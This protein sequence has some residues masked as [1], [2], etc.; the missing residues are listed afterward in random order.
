MTYGSGSVSRKEERFYRSGALVPAAVI[1]LG[2]CVKE[3][4]VKPYMYGH[5]LRYTY[6]GLI[7][8]PS[9]SGA[10]SQS[11]TR[12]TYMRSV[13]RC[14]A[15]PMSKIIMEIDI[16]RG[17]RSD[18]IMEIVIMIAETSRS[19]HSSQDLHD[20]IMMFLTSEWFSSISLLNHVHMFIMRPPNNK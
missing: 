15:A 16:S 17:P 20:Q 12:L 19:K 18:W 2:I 10:K 14:S 7:L 1:A 9:L 3:S 13:G 11:R 4:C 5:P 8:D 6:S